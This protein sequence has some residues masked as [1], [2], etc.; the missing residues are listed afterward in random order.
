MSV[1]SKCSHPGHS[2]PAKWQMANTS[3]VTKGRSPLW[4]QVQSLDPKEEVELQQGSPHYGPLLS[5]LTPPLLI[6]FLST[7]G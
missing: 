1:I 2:L 7:A 6:L 5:P 3:L 4:L